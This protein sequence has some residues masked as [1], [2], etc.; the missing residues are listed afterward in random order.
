MEVAGSFSA[1][2][3]NRFNA[4]AGRMLNLFRNYRDEKLGINKKKP[5]KR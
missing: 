5:T 2:N 3:S 4:T 1:I